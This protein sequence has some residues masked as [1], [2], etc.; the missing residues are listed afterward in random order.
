MVGA[1]KFNLVS[2]DQMRNANHYGELIIS[3]VECEGLAAITFARNENMTKLIK[4]KIARVATRM[5]SINCRLDL[6]NI[7]GTMC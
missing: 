6:T 5:Q 7:N 2:V 3:M 4:G 1:T